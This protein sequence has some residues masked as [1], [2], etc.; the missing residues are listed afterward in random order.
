MGEQDEHKLHTIDSEGD[1]VFDQWEY[2]AQMCES[3]PDNDELLRR[4]LDN[5]ERTNIGPSPEAV[6][7][8][9]GIGAEDYSELDNNPAT[10]RSG[11]RAQKKKALECKIY[12]M[13]HNSLGKAPRHKHTGE[14]SQLRSRK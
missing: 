8:M 3:A 14:N 6:M 13:N 4:V 5:S 10:T 7:T 11:T 1:E 2:S 12:V 9:I